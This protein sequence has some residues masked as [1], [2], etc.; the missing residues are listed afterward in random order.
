MLH[1]MPISA[2]LLFDRTNWKSNTRKSDEQ[3]ESASNL[4][5]SMLD[6]ISDKLSSNHTD[7]CSKAKEKLSP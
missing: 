3:R 5:Y 2:D 7:N 1:V 6:P 4:S